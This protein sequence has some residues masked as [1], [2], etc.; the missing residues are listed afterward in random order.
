MGAGALGAG[1]DGDFPGNRGGCCL[2]QKNPGPRARLGSWGGQRGLG[3]AAFPPPS[4][5]FD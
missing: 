2:P 5:V 4:P 3:G 1:Q